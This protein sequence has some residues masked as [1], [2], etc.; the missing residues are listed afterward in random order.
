MRVFTTIV[1]MFLLSTGFLKAEDEH[2]V[3]MGCGISKKAYM[4]E[5]AKVYEKETGIKF[6]MAGG[7]AT[8]GIR[9]AAKNEADI[10]GTCRYI[11]LT[12]NGAADETEN[13][14]MIHVGWDALAVV[15][16]KANPVDGLTVKQVQRVFQRKLRHWRSVGGPDELIELVV[17]KGKISGVGRLFRQLILNDEDYEFSES[18]SFFRS[19][20]PLEKNLLKRKSFEYGIGVTG[21]SSAKRTDLKVLKINGVAPTKENIASGTY[22]YFRPLYLAMNKNARKEAK[23]F[24]EF[25]LSEQGQKIID[26]AGTVN[27]AKGKKLEKLW[28]EKGFPL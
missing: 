10:G 12:P 17:R 14:D 9:L 15:V 18:A 25:V 22:P 27:L 4:G 13:V 3:W 7:G 6:R 19:S 2:L 1:V 11:L 8:K 20:G 24:V 28:V 5:M 16:N 26:R 21:I 23:D